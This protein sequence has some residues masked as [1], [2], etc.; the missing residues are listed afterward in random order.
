MKSP[1]QL[2]QLFCIIIVLPSLKA[3]AVIPCQL[4]V[5]PFP[6]GRPSYLAACFSE[7]SNNARYIS[8]S[9]YVARS[10]KTNIAQ[11]LSFLE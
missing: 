11:T 2:G 1:V 8:P 5:Q 6:E 9:M 10:I 3:D 4:R 7:A